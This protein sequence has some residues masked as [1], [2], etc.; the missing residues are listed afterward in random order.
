MRLAGSAGTGGV[1]GG[2][3]TVRLGGA[4]PA[5]GGGGSTGRGGDSGGGAV[6]RL[7]LIW[8][9]WRSPENWPCS[10]TIEYMLVP[11]N[12]ATAPAAHL[13]LSRRP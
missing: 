4:G 9:S 2:G 13:T 12:P 3:V 7:P 6:D 5:A 1:S 8:S 10:S 11:R